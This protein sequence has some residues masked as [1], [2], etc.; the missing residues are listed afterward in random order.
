MTVEEA[1]LSL[2]AR[3]QKRPWFNLIGIGEDGGR[4][5]IVLYVWTLKTPELREFEHGWRGFSVIIRKAGA[6]RPLARR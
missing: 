2:Q 3:F 6:A 5:A 4:P 1:A